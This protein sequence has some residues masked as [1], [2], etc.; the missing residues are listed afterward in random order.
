MTKL[1]ALAAV[2]ALA[3]ALMAGATTASAGP[4][5]GWDLVTPG[6]SPSPSPSVTAT[7]MGSDTGWD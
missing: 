1:R 2:A 4:D 6:S 5:T 3:A 7:T